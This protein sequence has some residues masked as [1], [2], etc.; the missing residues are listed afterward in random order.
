MSAEEAFRELARREALLSEAQE[1]AQLGSWEVDL[2]SRIHTWSDETYRILGIAKKNAAP[3]WEDILAIVHI[4]DRHML[5]EAI[6]WPLTQRAFPAID[7]RIGTPHGERIVHMRGRTFGEQ[8]NPQ[9]LVGFV[10]DVTAARG[11]QREI[12]RRAAQDDVVAQ[13]SQNAL[14]GADPQ[15]LFRTAA[16]LAGKVLH[17]DVVDVLHRVAGRA[18]QLVATSG[19][20]TAAGRIV[21]LDESSSMALALGSA[22]VAVIDE[23]TSETVFAQPE[24]D[25]EVQARSG[26][27]A[28]IF[29]S[30]WRPVGAIA[31]YNR[32]PTKFSGDD[33][34]F[35]Q[36]IASVLAQALDRLR[37]DE[38]VRT[39]A[40]AQIAI[41]E[42]ARRFADGV[43]SKLL[44]DACRVVNAVLGT[45]IARYAERSD[46]DSPRSQTGFTLR[47]PAPVVVTDYAAETRFDAQPFINEGFVSSISVAVGGARRT[48]GVL[49]VQSRTHRTFTDQE[50]NFVTAVA[51]V[52]GEAMDRDAA[53]TALRAAEQE[54]ERLARD[55]QLLLESTYEAI[56]AIDPNGIC[57]LANRAAA[58]A[59][60]IERSQLIGMHLHDVIHPGCPGCP[61]AQAN[62]LAQ[63]HRVH[64]ATFT[65]PD[66]SQFPVEYGVAPILDDSTPKGAVLTFSDVT[67]TRKLEAQL[68]QAHR[69]TSLGRLAATMAHEFNNVLMGIS[70]FVELLRRGDQT[71][72]RRLTALEHI[73]KS[74]KRGKRISDEILRYTNPAEPVLEPVPVAAWADSFG[75]EIRSVLGSNYDVTIEV[76]DP[77][78]TILADPMQMHQI[79]TNLALNA[80]DAMPEGGPL[81]IR[82]ASEPKESAFAFG[83]VKDPDKFVHVAVEDAGAGIH[84]D[85]LRHIFEPL[86]TTK[87]TGTGLGLAVTHQVVK[88]HGGD[89]FVET[90]VGLG[91]T[92]HIFL[93]RAV[94]PDAVTPAPHAAPHTSR[95]LRRVL[96][97]EDEPAVASGVAMLLETEGIEVDVVNTGAEVMDALARR[98]PDAVVLD[99]GLPDM[100]GTAVYRMIAERYPQL[101]VIFSTGHGDEK[102][103]E[104]YLASEHVGFLMKPYDIARLIE[105]L[106]RVT[107][108]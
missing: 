88:R 55:I 104:P 51:G 4:D 92:F 62:T 45:D 29:D 103:L 101:P 59:L 12:E 70:P 18:M 49:T 15:T 50:V 36:A 94:R 87:R 35:V 21:L 47:S 76:A 34:R 41:A 14:R 77:S 20:T 53:R 17:V 108:S 102:E 24:F 100:D 90:A 66:G 26:M 82:F 81:R 85:V 73:T 106:E 74:V 10:Q 5:L 32:T 28:S 9:R 38:D 68:E 25:A 7:L 97:V 99:I 43:T 33:V 72:E 42:L 107:R 54:R 80:R 84:P 57:T 19:R 79:L 58:S 40:A 89:L 3:S 52:A 71:F 69:L 67:E 13:L 98:F 65:R 44:D 16:R 22:E 39:Q 86:F 56:C 64:N 23:A 95:R 61:I 37:K 75:N 31:I 30:Q 6:E 27:I 60:G 83:F 2:R 8:D 91:S 78:L 1:I 63:P 93:P 46:D 105:S 11:A 96:L 48:F